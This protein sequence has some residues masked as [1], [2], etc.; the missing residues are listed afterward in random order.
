MKDTLKIRLIKSAKFVM[1][2]V[3]HVV[4]VQAVMSARKGI[5]VME[6]IYYAKHAVIIVV[7]AQ[8]VRHVL[9]VRLTFICQMVF[10]LIHVRWV[11]WE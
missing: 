6:L 8:T 4:M 10:V 9:H 11:L 3:K 7:I 1:R 2:L 5:I